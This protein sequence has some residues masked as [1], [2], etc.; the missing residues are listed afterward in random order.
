[1]ENKE[2]KNINNVQKEQR[3][4]SSKS[5]KSDNKNNIAII[6]ISGMVKVNKEIE[7]TLYRLKIRRKYACVVV[8][9][10]KEILGMLKKVRYHVAYGPISKD[11]YDKLIKARGKKG[12]DGKLKSFFRLHPP[13]GGIKSK[14][15][16][17]K[18]VLGNNK[19]DINKLIE[20]ML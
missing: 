6:R 8:E 10:T 13:R 5:S 17:P 20:R 19:A 18:G 7:N 12:T 1:M 15:Q 9:P 2:Q 3:K 16:Y 11:V 4:E 14:L